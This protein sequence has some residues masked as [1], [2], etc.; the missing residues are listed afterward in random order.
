MKPYANTLQ[1][2][3]LAAG[4]TCAWATVWTRDE[5]ATA[6]LAGGSALCFLALPWLAYLRPQEKWAV[7][8]VLGLTALL[9]YGVLMPI[10]GRL[11]YGEHGRDDWKIPALLLTAVL[12]V[13]VPVVRGLKLGC[14]PSGSRRRDECDTSGTSSR[15]RADER[16]LTDGIRY[17]AARS[18]RKKIVVVGTLLLMGWL[19]A[20]FF[21][22]RRPLPISGGT[23]E[24]RRVAEACL[25]LLRSRQPDE[26]VLELT[27]DRIPEA[28]R[29]LKPDFVIVDRRMVFFKVQ[30]A[31][32]L[33]E[34]QLR[35]APTG[36]KGV[37]QLTGR[38]GEFGS[39]H[40]QLLRIQGEHPK[41]PGR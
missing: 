21:I 40:V 29:I 4:V 31:E 23:P 13:V 27:D 19:V 7:G 22:N 17:A 12:S 28:I 5:L 18:T 20:A 33:V 8:C 16:D 2:L 25:Q 36:R 37:W 26:F 15:P 34:Y 6:W 35:P 10:W 3:L 24:Q 38:G 14:R 9:T 39:D 11:W 41:E 1:W 32:G 30:S